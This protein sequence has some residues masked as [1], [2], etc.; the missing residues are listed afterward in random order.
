[1][2]KKTDIFIVIILIIFSALY[3]RYP[4]FYISGIADLINFN[5]FMY[6]SKR[7]LFNPDAMFSLNK[8]IANVAYCESMPLCYPPGIY[9]ITRMFS[10]LRDN[11]LTM[12]IFI[13]LLQIVTV[14]F[15]Y[16]SLRKVSNRIVSI[17]F[18]IFLIFYTAS[19][20]VVVDTFI[21]PLLAIT[22]FLLLTLKDTNK[23]K[24]LLLLGVL[25]GIIFFIRQNVGLFL[26]NAVITWLLIS[27]L[28]FNAEE[29]D[30]KRWFLWIITVIY[31]ILGFIIIKTINNVDDKIWYVLCFIAFW[32]M[33]SIGLYYR[34]DIGINLSNLIKK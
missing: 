26:T 10:L 15:E 3:L 8:E 24:S 16:L 2:G 30:K 9:F 31:L 21:Q 25:T 18:S 32:L 17:S 11:Q 12:H 6:V 22:V 34:K 19:I 14:I 33:F 4:V 28:F 29:K 13:F 27:S 5:T 23:N 1:M 20:T 7:V